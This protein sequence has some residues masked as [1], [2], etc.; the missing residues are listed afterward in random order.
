MV[1]KNERNLPDLDSIGGSLILNALVKRLGPTKLLSLKILPTKSYKSQLLNQSMQ[2]YLATKTHLF[3]WI[4]SGLH[5]KTGRYGPRARVWPMEIAS[6]LGRHANSL[7]DLRTV[8]TFL[9]LSFKL[10]LSL[11]KMNGTSN[12][13]VF[14]YMRLS[15]PPHKLNNPGKITKENLKFRPIVCP[16]GTF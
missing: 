13:P 8:Q 12:R 3:S 11:E 16:W 14:L 1:R 15:N 10:I 9:I 7:K 4:M 5:V 2:F 6:K